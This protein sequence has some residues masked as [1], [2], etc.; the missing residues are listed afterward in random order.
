MRAQ[1]GVRRK[2]VMINRLGGTVS[3]DGLCFLP[4]SPGQA[5]RQHGQCASPGASA[6]LRLA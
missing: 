3:G 2:D 6:T 1:G 4:L 5:M